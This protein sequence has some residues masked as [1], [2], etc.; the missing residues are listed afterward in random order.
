MS[1]TGFT[2]DTELTPVLFR[3]EK[4]GDITAVFPCEPAN[5]QTMTMTCYAH[6]GQHSGCDYGWYL[7]TRP[8]KPAEYADL[9]AELES[10]PYGYRLKIYQRINR[11]LRNKFM[12]EVHRLNQPVPETV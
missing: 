10:T 9:K 5:L 4:D 6:I 3:R 1:D 2:Q 12:A 7:T 8:A 11:R